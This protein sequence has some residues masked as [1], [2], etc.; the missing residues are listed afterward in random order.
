MGSQQMWLV[1]IVPRP[2]LK[3]YAQYAHN[4]E[5]RG[6]RVKKYG[7]IVFWTPSTIRIHKLF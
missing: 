2:Q 5:R 4:G 6:W 7:N 1:L 3:V